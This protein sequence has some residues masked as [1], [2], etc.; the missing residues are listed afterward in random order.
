MITGVSD[1]GHAAIA[2]STE[3][4]TSAP[5][6]TYPLFAETTIFLLPGNGRLGRD[7][8]VLRPITI[9]LPRVVALKWAR[10]SGRCQGR[11]PLSPIARSFAIATMAFNLRRRLLSELK[12][13]KGIA[14]SIFFSEIMSGS[15]G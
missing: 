9:G 7:S 11:V 2:I 10:S 15:E 12:V 6:A 8:H 1:A 4:N 5:S 3:P 13:E 14:P